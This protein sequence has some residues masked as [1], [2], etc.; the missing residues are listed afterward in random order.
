MSKNPKIRSSI[1]RFMS[2]KDETELLQMYTELDAIAR[3]VEK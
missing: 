3:K 1:E 2:G